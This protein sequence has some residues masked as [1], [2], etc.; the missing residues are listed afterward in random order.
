MKMN[1]VTRFNQAVEANPDGVAVVADERPAKYRELAELSD[2]YAA[3]LAEHGVRAG[4]R[5]AFMVPPGLDF[6][7]LCFALFKLGA[8][9]V[10]IDAGMDLRNLR[11]CLEEA[12]PEVFIGSPRAHEARV[13]LGW[14][15]RTVQLNVTAGEPG[16][17]GGPSLADFPELTSSLDPTDVKADDTAMIL[18]TTGSTGPPKV[19]CTRTRSAARS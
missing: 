2:R 19:P 12:E 18:F 7:A 4:T 11:Q 9:P 1:I 16:D 14:G 13:S 8:V 5:I 17:W 6:M 3:G 10:L 15:S